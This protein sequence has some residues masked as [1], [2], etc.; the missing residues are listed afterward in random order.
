[1]QAVAVGWQAYM[2]TGS[3]FYLG[4][5]GLAQFLPM[6]LLTLAVGHIADRYDRRLIARV[7]QIVEAIAAAALAFGSAAG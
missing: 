3:A 2:L 5:V 7:C 6:F 4:L 1:M